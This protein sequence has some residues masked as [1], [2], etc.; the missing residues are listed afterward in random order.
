M[1]KKPEAFVKDIQLGKD[2][3]ELAKPLEISNLMSEQKITK[4]ILLSNRFDLHFQIKN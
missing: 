2:D 4:K 1:S 3:R